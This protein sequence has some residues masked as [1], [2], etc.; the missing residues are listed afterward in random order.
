MFI[1]TCTSRKQYF[2]KV[3]KSIKNVKMD[4][5]ERKTGPKSPLAEKPFKAAKATK[6]QK[7]QIAADSPL[8]LTHQVRMYSFFG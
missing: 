1:W 7:F 8:L 2:F 4:G 6:V 5:S 3:Q